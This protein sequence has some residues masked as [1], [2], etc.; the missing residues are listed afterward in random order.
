MKSIF[1]YTD[2]RDYL[3]DFYE[4]RKKSVCGFTYRG[5]AAKAGMGSPAFIR[6]IILG[7]KTPRRESVHKLCRALELTGAEA[8]F[9]A[10]L[11]RF[12][13]AAAP[14]DKERNLAVMRAIAGQ[15]HA[16]VVGADQY[17]YYQHWYH[18]VI[19]ELAAA[20]AG[21]L[22]PD[23]L[24]GL[25]SPPIGKRAAKKALHLLVDKGFL[26]QSET[27]GYELADK[28]VTTGADVH[29]LAIRNH[30][31]QMAQR[32]LEAI[33]SV[34]REERD[35]SGITMGVS[36]ECAE[37]VKEELMLCRKRIFDILE[38]SSATERVYRVNLQFFPVSQRLRS[39]EAES[40]INSRAD[41]S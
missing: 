21:P 31:R 19:R 16:T 13:T 25:V 3:R 29:S 39:T 6:D 17:D 22:D 1:T 36:E 10:A 9:F 37:R 34:A 11:V 26:R 5:F 32:A 4:E 23:T 15:A 14:A 30:H 33:D 2:F 35:F 8:D 41:E 40:E 7:K 27:G 12:N 20:A 24:G 18:S 28:T 38:Q